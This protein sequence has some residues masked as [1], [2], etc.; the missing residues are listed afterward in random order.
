MTSLCNDCCCASSPCFTWFCRYKQNELSGF[1][2]SSGPWQILWRTSDSLLSYVCSCRDS[3]PIVVPI[4]LNTFTPGTGTVCLLYV[5]NCVG[6]CTF[7]FFWVPCVWVGRGI[8]ASSEFPQHV[9]PVCFGPDAWAC[10][11]IWVKVRSVSVALVGTL[12]HPL[13]LPL[14]QKQT[15][16]FWQDDSFRQVDLCGWECGSC[17]LPKEELALASRLLLL[18]WLSVLRHFRNSN[19]LDCCCWCIFF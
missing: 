2:V 5:N 13:S 10:V 8:P 6:S 19:F 17:H 16:T 14:C 12:R 9:Q 11:Y 7:I 18:V 1:W 3:G 4:N 15:R